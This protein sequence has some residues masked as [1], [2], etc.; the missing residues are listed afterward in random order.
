MD[1]GIIFCGFYTIPCVLLPAKEKEALWD[2]GIQIADLMS[3]F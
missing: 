3:Q 2:L 1:S